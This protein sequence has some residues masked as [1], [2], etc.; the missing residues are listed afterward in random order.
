MTDHADLLRQAAA[1]ARETANSAPP[2]PYEIDPGPGYHRQI[3]G[4]DGDPIAATRQWPGGL[5]YD[6]DDTG[7]AEQTAAHIVLWHPGVALAVAAW[8]DTVARGIPA[9]RSALTAPGWDEGDDPGEV[10]EQQYRH[11]LTVARALLNEPKE[12]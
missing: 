5:G 3:L 12:N 2:G 10:I 8:L 7:S 4:T 6:G 1:K 9:F 11:Q